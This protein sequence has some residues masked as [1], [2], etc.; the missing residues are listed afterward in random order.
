M[1]PFSMAES[2][3]ALTTSVNYEK[4]TIHDVA[5]AAGVSAATV[6][7]SL[8]L[9][10]QVKPAVRAHVIATAE[11]LGYLADGAARA[12]A[13]RRSG[14]VG[15]IVPAL[16]NPI[17]AT[18]IAALQQRLDEQGRVLLIASTGNDSAREV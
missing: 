11:R 13:S 8:K 16:D 18:C 9:P 3:I 7:R 17:F 6:S 12:L 4:I 2:L 10:D 5:Y 14:A 1:V 15:A